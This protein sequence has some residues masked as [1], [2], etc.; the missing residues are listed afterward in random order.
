MESRIVQIMISLRS[1]KEM[2]FYKKRF[3]RCTEYIKEAMGFRFDSPFTLDS[4]KSLLIK[5]NSL[6]KPPRAPASMPSFPKLSLIFFFPF[7]PFTRSVWRL[8]ELIDKLPSLTSHLRYTWL[9]R[10]HVFKFLW[11]SSGEVKQCW[12]IE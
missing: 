10:I 4:L 3:H 2:N 1:S 9:N 6:N 11:V 5:L 12:T 8:V 7:F